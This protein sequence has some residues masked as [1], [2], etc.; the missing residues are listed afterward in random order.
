MPRMSHLGSLLGSLLILLC[1]A[2]SAAAIMATKDQLL[3][4]VVKVKDGKYTAVEYNI[5][6]YGDLDDTKLQIK[7]YAEAPSEGVISRDNFVGAFAVLSTMM[8]EE[9]VKDTEFEETH[10]TEE[11]AAP[12]GN[13]DLEINMYMSAG[14]IQFEVINTLTKETTRDTSTWED[15]FED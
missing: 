9:L 8:I 6:S 5:L 4:D 12:I 14:G 3:S 2:V 11:I 15:M 1:L 7:T 10:D 13:V